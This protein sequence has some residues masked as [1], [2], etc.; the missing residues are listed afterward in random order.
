M[1]E[2]DPGFWNV[3]SI[4]EPEH[5]RAMLRKAKSVLH[6][7]FDDVESRETED[8]GFRPMRG[9]EWGEIF[10]LVDRTHPEG[11]LVHCKMGVSRSAAVALVILL[12]ALTGQPDA[13]RKALDALM[14]IR[15]QACPNGFVLGLGL[16]NWMG[17]AE[18]EAVV[19]GVLGDPRIRMNRAS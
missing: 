7:A 11:L 8:L 6:V 2:M 15:P 1:V 13:V 12:R 3:I 9:G 14:A 16:K 17:E 4:R 18:A 5:S 19:V 10:A